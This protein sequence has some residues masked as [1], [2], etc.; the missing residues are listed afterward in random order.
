MADGRPHLTYS[1]I[2][3]TITQASDL[4]K[5]KGLWY[6]AKIADGWSTECIFGTNSPAVS[7]GPRSS[8]AIDKNGRPR[9]VITTS[10]NDELA[11]LWMTAGGSWQPSHWGNYG[12]HPSIARGPDGAIWG[13]WG[14]GNSYHDGLR[15]GRFVIDDIFDEQTVDGPGRI[16]W[17]NDLAL[18]ADGTPHIAYLTEPAETGLARAVKYATKSGG[19]WQ[20]A[21]VD[22]SGNFIGVSIALDAVG[23][24]HIAY[25]TLSGQ[26]F[27]AR[28]D[29]TAWKT[30]KLADGSCPSVAVDPSGGPHVIYVAAADGSLR[31]RFLADKVWGDEVVDT[32][33]AGVYTDVVA[34]AGGL[35][36]AYYAG[37]TDVR[38]AFAPWPATP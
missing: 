25:D 28:W 17:A 34:A 27:Y 1:V 22:A 15:Y 30:E 21:T 31:H 32:G 12:T 6:A 24:P 35:H 19:A 2:T 33:P 18:A 38:Y 36:V 20:L 7:C 10:A 5:Q 16:G 4:P 23:V 11:Q 26:V 3:E 37:G 14:G 8:V 29:G 13:C 9:V